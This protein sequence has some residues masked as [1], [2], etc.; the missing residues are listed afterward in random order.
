MIVDDSDVI[1]NDDVNDITII[2]NNVIINDI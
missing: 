1:V 2:T